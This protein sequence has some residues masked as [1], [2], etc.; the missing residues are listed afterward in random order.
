[1]QRFL[2]SVIAIISIGFASAGAIPFIG[3]GVQDAYNINVQ[4]FC[5]SSQMHG[6]A[7]ATACLQTAIDTAFNNSIHQVY[8]PAGA[9]LITSSPIYQDPPGN[10]RSNIT[11]PSTSAFSLNFT[12]LG[13]ANHESP[14]SGNGCDI[15]PT[16]NNDVAWWIGPGRG[17]VLRGVN[18]LGPSAGGAWRCNH[19]SVAT[20]GAWHPAGIAVSE[21]ASNTL[22][23]NT[24]VENFY[25]GYELGP[26]G[27]SLADSDTFRKPDF[28]NVCIGVDNQ[29]TQAFIVDIYDPVG[30]A[31][32][33]ISAING[34][35][36][37]V[38]GGNLS[39]PSTASNSFTVGSFGSFTATISFSNSFVYSFQATITAPDANVF[40]AYNTYTLVT[41][42]FGVI[43]LQMTAFNS[44][45]G[46]ATFQI[47]PPWGYYYFA[48]NNALSTTTLQAEISA[49]TTL[50]AA[51]M[52][53]TFA[54]AN[55]HVWGGHVENG[56]PT[57]F[58]NTLTLFGGST[59]ASAQGVYFDEDPSQAGHAPSTN[60]SAANLAQYYTQATFPFIWLSNGQLN[61]EDIAFDS[62]APLN[63]DAAPWSSPTGS[64]LTSGFFNSNLLFGSHLTTLTGGFNA[65]YT[66]QAGA[67]F[68][69]QTYP[70]NSALL[71]IGTWDTD[72][73]L[74]TALAPGGSNSDR[75]RNIGFE[76][77]PTWG[78]RPAGWTRPCLTPAQVT[79][80]GTTL[81][82]LF[83]TAN[84]NLTYPLLYGG[85]Q[86]QKCDWFV[87]TQTTYNVVSN[88]HGYSYGQAIS[89]AIAPATITGVTGTAS[90]Y[91]FAV[92]GVLG[93]GV[94]YSPVFVVG[95][96]FTVA[97]AN[98]SSL[99]GTYTVTSSS[100]GSVTATTTATGTWVSGGTAKG[101]MELEWATIGKG[102]VV[103]VNDTNL[104]FP[105]LQVGLTTSAG[106]VIYEVTGV[107]PGLGYITVT[108]F[109]NGAGVV[110]GVSGTVYRGQTVAQESYSLTQY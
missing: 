96:T 15:K 85:Q 37:Y 20:Q 48:G 63:I 70:I 24:W 53:T 77:S 103:Y 109:Q 27:P 82:S 51:E 26:N 72:Y 49:A 91:T 92:S 101:I 13:G 41:T 102:F 93:D 10:L 94:A 99:N 67:Y 65:R 90:P 21:L 71:G 95:D 56:G 58:F 22:I 83:G 80:A 60:P 66:P 81:A 46:V 105:G 31:T 84:Y 43:P 50:Y 34:E 23:E 29:N 18:I 40:T 52:L 59:T 36:T 61:L 42:D 44:G 39:A 68:G 107:I 19:P 45:T 7:D 79:A 64:N 75:Q 9:N 57:M 25:S 3:V 62:Q 30:N 108:P 74:S 11:A 88:H 17:M 98:P 35:N 28:N 2:L 76:Q 6:G 47:Y 73:F 78:Y 55:I 12:G 14:G 89:N 110:S 8:C 87:G 86:Y 1:M 38:Y 54:G 69:I 4:D 97:G 33:A 104:F 32:T 106:N 100:A 5:A 16:F